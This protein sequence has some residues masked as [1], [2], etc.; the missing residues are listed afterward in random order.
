MFTLA[1]TYLRMFFLMCDS[2]LKLHFHLKWRQRVNKVTYSDDLLIE[3]LL[4]STIPETNFSCNNCS[5]HGFG[6][7]S[8]ICFP[9]TLGTYYL[10][11][12]LVVFS[13][14]NFLQA[15]WDGD[16]ESTCH[17]APLL[18]VKV[19]PCVQWCKN[20][21]GLGNGGNWVFC[22]TGLIHLLVAKEDVNQ[23]LGLFAP[24]IV[25]GCCG[26]SP[27]GTPVKRNF[28]FKFCCAGVMSQLN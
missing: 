18:S 14:Y 6:F 25:K 24:K 26:S 28:L 3:S 2:L 23:H 9:A 7:I 19:K 8:L 21:H 22:H 16:E 10:F 13:L 12:G 15:V 11:A 5:N 20:G 17:L 4:I 1:T 27:S